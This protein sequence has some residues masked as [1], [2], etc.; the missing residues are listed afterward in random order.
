MNLQYKSETEY[1]VSPG[2]QKKML[3]KVLKCEKQSRK[4]G[5]CLTHGAKCKRCK[6]DGCDRHIQ[7][8]GYCQSHHPDYVPLG[9]LSRKA[10][11]VLEY[12]IDVGL[13]FECEKRF[14]KCK[15]IRQLPF[16]FYIPI[17]NLCIEYDGEQHVKA[18][19]M[20][21]GDKALQLTQKR[22]EIKNKFCQDNNINLLRIPHTTKSRQI[23][24]LINKALHES[25]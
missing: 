11:M 20:W 25:C 19:K 8:A 13:P 9:R 23:P 3:C 2:G 22:D 17:Y 10:Q 4:G 6:I 21:G 14:P 16:D 18:V 12:L 15:H 7:K 1:R 5:V 24:H